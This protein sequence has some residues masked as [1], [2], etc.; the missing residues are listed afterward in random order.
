VHLAS[1]GALIKEIG[2]TSRV[3]FLDLE[4]TLLRGG[5]EVPGSNHPLSQ[6]P[7][8]AHA[9]GEDAVKAELATQRRWASKEYAG[10]LEW[11]EATCEIHKRFGLTREI[12]S[13]LVEKAQL[14]P[15]AK[16]LVDYL[17]Q[18]GFKT[19]LMTGAVKSFADKVQIE[20]G[21]DHAFAACEYFF[22]K[23]GKLIH[24]NTLPCDYEGK[25]NLMEVVVKEHGTK[26]DQC[27]FVGDGKNDVEL[28]RSVGLSVCFNGHDDLKAI[29]TIV[30]S[31][32]KGEENL[33]E[34]IDELERRI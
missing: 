13:N 17:R 24:W 15:G 14:M 12:M 6:W 32:K 3:A 30:I 19:V 33:V 20:L 2:M 34:V 25:R 11:V 27:L 29:S 22:D 5:I 28:A 8:I 7:A 9:L 31:Q 26:S 16:D 18:E 10:Y 21:I 4:G 23:S 1:Q